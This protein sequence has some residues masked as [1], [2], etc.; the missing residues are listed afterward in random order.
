MK[1]IVSILLVILMLCSCAQTGQPGIDLEPY[2]EAKSPPDVKIQYGDVSIT[3]GKGTYSWEYVENGKNVWVEADSDHPLFWEDIASFSAGTEKTAKL[4]FDER[5]ESYELKRWEVEPGYFENEDYSVLEKGERVISEN[6]V[7]EVPTDGKMY[8]YEIYVKYEGGGNCWYGFRINSPDEWG[9]TLSVKSVTPTGATLVFKQSEG[10]PTGELMTG[11]YYRLEDKNGEL[12]YIVEGDVAWTS[13]AY[14]I[15][16]DGEIQMQANWEWLYGT[17]EPGT[18]RI[19]KEVMDFRG[20]GD[21]DEKEYFAEFTI[22]EKSVKSMKI[23][24]IVDG[25]ESG[26]LVLAGEN[27]GDVMTLN[28]KNVPVFL[29]GEPADSSVLMDGMTIHIYHNGEILETYPAS[30]GKVGEIHAFSIGS[31]NQPGGGFFDLCGLYLKVLDD[32]WEVDSGLNGGAEYVSLDLV[33]APGSLTDSEIAAMSWIF[34]NKYNVQVLTFTL[35]ELKEQ[36]YLTAAGG[37]NNLYQ[38][39]N[40]VLL[41]ITSDQNADETEVY[42]LPVLRFNAT[43]WRSPLGAYMFMGCKALWPAMGTW[44]DYTIDSQAIS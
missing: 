1:K 8:V 32:L 11:S 37:S 36:G 4:I 41:S 7:F 27:S 24:K 40:G 26:K 31:K 28:A 25:A 21:F 42:S 19:Y 6:G 23:M 38:W 5:M 34:E 30:F 13:E 14:M 3:A 20:A 35:D 29:D 15:K 18:Y 33:S 9:L 10:N 39:D 44:S 17:L 2:K 43:K 22:G 16:K 12:P